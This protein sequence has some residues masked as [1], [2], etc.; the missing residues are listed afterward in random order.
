M[1]I[2]TGEGS[3]TLSIVTNAYYAKRVTDTTWQ[4]STTPGG[5]SISGITC[6]ATCT[7]AGRVANGYWKLN[8]A[9]SAWNNTP[10][11]FAR[12]VVDFENGHTA[13]DYWPAFTEVNGIV[14]QT[15][16]SL[17]GNVV[18]TDGMSPTPTCSTV[19]HTVVDDGGVVG[20]VT[21]AP[22]TGIPTFVKAGWAKVTASLSPYPDKTIYVHICATTCT[23]PTFTHDGHVATSYTPGQSFIPTSFWNLDLCQMTASCTGDP[24]AYPM[25]FAPLMRDSG[26]NTSFSGV[27]T[28]G[29]NLASPS[30]TSCGSI[31][32]ARETQLFT[33]LNQWNLYA[34]IGM[35]P[36][37]IPTVPIGGFL[38]NAGFDRQT[39]AKNAL[40]WLKA[41]G[42]VVHLTGEDEITSNTGH[43]NPDCTGVVGT[44]CFT[45]ITRIGSTATVHAPIFNITEAVWNQANGTGAAFLI[46]GAPTNTCLNGW[47]YLTRKTTTG[48]Y[49]PD[50]DFTTACTGATTTYDATSDPGLT[51]QYLGVNPVNAVGG[52]YWIHACQLP[53]YVGNNGPNYTYQGWTSVNDGNG[54]STADTSLSSLTSNGSLLTIVDNGNLWTDGQSI[55]IQGASTAALN[56]LHVIHVVNANTATTPTTAASGSYTSITDPNLLISSDCNL[57]T[58]SYAQLHTIFHAGADIAHLNTII[59]GSYAVPQTVQSWYAPTVSDSIMTYHPQGCNIVYGNE[60]PVYKSQLDNQNYTLNTRAYQPALRA[61]LNSSVKIYEKQHPGYLF[62]P[63][64]DNPIAQQYLDRP[65][66]QVGG[67]MTDLTFGIVSERVYTLR[68]RNSDEYNNTAVGGQS[69]SGIGPEYGKLWASIAYAF[70]AMQHLDR[71]ILQ[72]HAASPYFGRMYN[73]LQTTSSYGN[74]LMVVCLLDGG[75]TESRTV[76]LTGIRLAG[77]SIYRMSVSGYRLRFDALAGNPTSDTYTMCGAGAGEAVAYIAQPSGAVSDLTPTTFA[78]PS[79]LPYGATKYGIRVGYYPGDMNDDPVTDCTAG[80][81]INLHR[82]GGPAWFQII[83]ANNSWTPLATG[84]PTMLAGQGN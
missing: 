56:G 29:V 80:C 74:M 62:D 46:K 67:I 49:T 65:E 14:G 26:I 25:Y 72:P 58:D 6:A 45:N 69:G 52:V 36:F 19:T 35:Q 63:A 54:Q 61:N 22:T 50:F 17:C 84:D 44:P 33:I 48:S 2:G 42:R 71:Y 32:A 18:Y 83:Y 78:P 47:Q 70:Q 11:A 68:T 21:V 37:Q 57:P 43:V 40:A 12:K 4:V 76:D 3:G 9:N 1:T 28:P 75:T 64:L 15:G 82:A 5:A 53:K 60:C 39:C 59:G 51:I 20:A 8:P 55:A 23:P 13:M 27:T 24:N 79:P 41:T 16:P 31:P 77:G 30:S 10:V 7:V 81:T 34:E 66:T 73:T 38:A